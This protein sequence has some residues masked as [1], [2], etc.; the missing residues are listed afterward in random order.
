MPRHKS[1]SRKNDPFNDSGEDTQ[2]DLEDEELRE[3]ELVNLLG[4]DSPVVRRESATEDF[5]WELYLESA[6]R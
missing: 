4:I 5:S 6:W 1:H 2:L 3:E